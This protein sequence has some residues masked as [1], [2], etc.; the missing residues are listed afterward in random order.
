MVGQRLFTGIAA[1]KKRGVDAERL[2]KTARIKVSA[3]LDAL[4]PGQTFKTQHWQY[5]DGSRIDVSVW[6]DG[7]G[8]RAYI[9]LFTMHEG[10]IDTFFWESGLLTWNGLVPYAPL[11]VWLGDRLR[12]YPWPPL[13]DNEYYLSPYWLNTQTP[14]ALY[15]DFALDLLVDR[16]YWPSLWTGKARLMMQ[17]LHAVKRDPREIFGTDI[18][19]H[20]QGI[21]HLGSRYWVVTINNTGAWV[22]ALYL[23]DTAPDYAKTGLSKLQ[24]RV[25]NDPTDLA[26][27]EAA[28]MAGLQREGTPVQIIDSGQIAAIF[29]EGQPMAYGWR[30]SPAK[31]EAAIVVMRE[32]C[33]PEF[34]DITCIGQF[35]ASLFTISADYSS[36][37]GWNASVNRPH[38]PIRS[39]PRPGW[40]SLYYPTYGLI[41]GYAGKVPGWGASPQPAGYYSPIG[42]TVQPLYCYYSRGGVLQI[43]WY[44]QHQVRVEN[45]DTRPTPYGHCSP[46]YERN[47]RYGFEGYIQGGFAIMPTPPQVEDFRDPYQNY[48]ID[49][50]RIAL[51]VREG[52]ASATARPTGSDTDFY[53]ALTY[54]CDAE[55]LRDWYEARS[56]YIPNNPLPTVGRVDMQAQYGHQEEQ[57]RVETYAAHPRVWS[58]IIAAFDAEAVYLLCR[59]KSTTRGEVREAHY[60]S[61]V[62]P[63]GKPFFGGS[64]TL[65]FYNNTET[66]VLLETTKTDMRK[67]FL[68]EYYEAGGWAGV[69]INGVSLSNTTLVA[70]AST[71]TEPPDYRLY[72]PHGY[73]P[74]ADDTSWSPFFPDGVI[75][76]QFVE[77]QPI[78][79]LLSWCGDGLYYAGQGQP[80]MRGGYAAHAGL[81]SVF[82]GGA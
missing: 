2:E 8:E 35:V 79:A 76:G 72:S 58:C 19:A 31:A 49:T 65:T 46:P 61:D 59:H 13:I 41:W 34:I 22:Q 39:R 14:A 23:P 78:K 4:L 56:P 54:F 21:W 68:P 50:Y 73:M 51:S 57:Y 44:V 27:A 17:A 33:M 36:V 6:R 74:F 10:R 18:N 20:Q 11:H 32:E 55:T 16:N 82:I 64:M 1:I 30:F 67:T 9:K 45:F 81:E 43:V 70:P 26:M 80:R 71:T 38:G 25:I 75:E 77:G 5:L 69:I 60:N 29:A 3:M 37:S 47:G 48:A 63:D 62:A 40:T 52:T 7:L 42:D 53:T 24:E 28:L 66:A 12:G 15:P